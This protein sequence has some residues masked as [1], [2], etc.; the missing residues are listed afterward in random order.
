[1]PIRRAD[2]TVAIALAALVFAGALL[3]SARL[4]PSILHY[5]TFD[6]W[7]ESDPPAFL[8]QMESREHDHHFRTRRHPLWSLL[9]YPAVNAIAG[10]AG[11]PIPDAMSVLMALLASI[12]IVVVFATLRLARLPRA[13][14]ALFTML[15]AVAA[16]S[17]FWLPVPES[18]VPGALTIALAVLLVALS[19]RGV[20]VPF[21]IC[22]LVSLL[23]FSI[24]TT[25]WT[26][27]IIMLAL[28]LPWRHAI[29][30]VGRTAAIAWGA[31]TVQHGL[32]PNAGS[33]LEIWI[34]SETKYLLSP[35]SSGWLAKVWAFFFHAIVAPALDTAYGFRLS[36]QGRLPGAGSTL[37]IGAVA[38]WI[39]LGAL[40]L[41]GLARIDLRRPLPLMLLLSALSQFALAMAFGIETFLYS[42]HW[43]PLLIMIAAVGSTAAS[44][45][46]SL[47]LVAVLV[48]AAGVNNGLRLRDGANGLRGL[49]E[50]ERRFTERVAALTE[51]DALIVCGRHAAAALGEPTAPAGQSP[52]TA[53]IEDIG[54]HIPTDAC[55]FSI[56]GPAPA[57]RGWVVSF[58]DWSMNAIETF[59]QRGARYFITPYV[60]GLRHGRAFLD[61]MN[62][63][64]RVV[65]RRSEWAFY[66]L[67]QPKR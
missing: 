15:V 48:V 62:Q 36:V 49:Y 6:Y 44:R 61:A 11:L 33:P 5:S 67:S 17:M 54:R 22:V 4:Q 38:L 42:L 45:R 59:R 41:R 56:D 51:P 28:V 47:G 66:D 18:Y 57:R 37:A 19:A 46:W 31:W 25:N 3:T 7:F 40:A 24:T 2:V 29:A 58:E 9:M 39:A 52:S 20:R 1:M 63:R 65:E 60:H 14:A 21:W 30:A 32:F 27:G 64:F 35:E 23:T 16:C 10:V 12:W 43:G 26:A 13:D 53:E 8:D 50:H 55:Y 34:A